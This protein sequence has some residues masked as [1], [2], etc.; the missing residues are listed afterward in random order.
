MKVPDIGT[1][2]TGFTRLR[3]QQKSEQ[4]QLIR[5]GIRHERTR[6]R[7]TQLWKTAQGGIYRKTEKDFK[8]K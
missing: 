6:L 8:S 7:S 4:L 1:M 3:I 2:F 5:S